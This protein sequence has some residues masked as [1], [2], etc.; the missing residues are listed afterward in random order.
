[1]SSWIV[2]EGTQCYKSPLLTTSFLFRQ[3]QHL[4]SRNKICYWEARFSPAPGLSLKSMIE[5]MWHWLMFDNLCRTLSSELVKVSFVSRGM[6]HH[7]LKF[8]F[9]FVINSQ[10]GLKC[11]KQ[12]VQTDLYVYV[13][14]VMANHNCILFSHYSCTCPC[15]LHYQDMSLLQNPF[16]GIRD[17]FQSYCACPEQEVICQ[18][19]LEFR[20][21]IQLL[22]PC[23]KLQEVLSF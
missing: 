12:I 19:R 15:T 14:S 4:F 11:H 6:V 21:M 9:P 2:R 20:L 17:C 16:V 18:A 10:W 13:L 22:L 5:V 3:C 1:M 7:Q 23:V 8:F